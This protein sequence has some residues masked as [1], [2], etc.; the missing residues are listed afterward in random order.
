[1][2]SL[3]DVI[4]YDNPL[5]DIN[6]DLAFKTY[7]INHVYNEKVE[8]TVPVIY[9]ENILV[10]NS[11]WLEIP[12]SRICEITINKKVDTLRV[13][14]SEMLTKLLNSGSLNTLSHIKS[15]DLCWVPWEELGAEGSQAEGM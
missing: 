3:E 15:L 9:A 1:M 4:V 14:S 11:S 10:L 13:E 8:S 6:E 7:P 2:T 12:F 5:K